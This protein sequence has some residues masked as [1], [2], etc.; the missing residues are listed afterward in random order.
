MPDEEIKLVIA[1]DVSGLVAGTAKAA[2]ATNEAATAMESSAVKMGA[3]GAAISKQAVDAFRQVQASAAGQDNAILQQAA[4]FQASGLSANQAAVALQ[5]LGYGQKESSAAAEWAAAQAFLLSNAQAAEASTAHVAAVAQVEHAASMSH[6]DRAMAHATARIAET[7]SGAGGLG[8]S[9]GRVA[10]QSETLGPILA[11]AFPV[12]GAIALVEI[13]SQV[14]AELAKLADAEQTA[15]D[16]NANFERQLLKSAEALSKMKEKAAELGGGS[17][18]AAAEN[19]S[20]LGNRSLDVTADVKK[21][22][23]RIEDSPGILKQFG[24]AVGTVGVEAWHLFDDASEDAQRDLGTFN[25]QVMD[26]IKQQKDLAPAIQDVERRI[27]VMNEQMSTINLAAYSSSTVENFQRIIAAES[28]FRDSL[29][30]L[31]QSESIERQNIQN[32]MQASLITSEQRAAESRLSVERAQVDSAVRLGMISEEQSRQILDREESQKLAIIRSTYD[33]KR[34]LLEQQAKTN[35]ETD[36]SAAFKS[37][38]EQQAAEESKIATER[39]QIATATQERLVALDQQR[40]K[41][42]EEISIAQSESELK[43]AEQAR[44]TGKITIDEEVIRRK[45]AEQDIYSAKVQAKVA[46]FALAGEDEKKQQ[47]IYT[48]LELL[49]IQHGSKLQ[50]IEA[51]GAKARAEVEEKEWTNSLQKREQD[52]RLSIERMA[53]EQRAKFDTLKIET[54]LNAPVFRHPAEDQGPVTA[55][56]GA[57]G[58]GSPIKETTSDALALAGALAT[59]G[60]PSQELLGNL[61]KI[62]Q[63]VPQIAAAVNEYTVAVEKTKEIKAET[64]QNITTD[65]QQLAIIEQK[66][67]AGVQVAADLERQKELQRD[68]AENTKIATAADKDQHDALTRLAQVTAQVANQMRQAMASSLQQTTAAFNHNLAEWMRG[69]ETFGTAMLRTWVSFAETAIQQLLRIAEQ[70][71]IT[72]AL[73]ALGL[74]SSTSASQQNAQQISGNVAVAA[75]DAAVAA[76]NTLAFE[77]GEGIPWPAAAADAAITYAIGAG[78]SALA[79]YEKGGVVEKTGPAL[80][81]AGEMILTAPASERMQAIFGGVPEAREIN[82]LA[83]TAAATGPGPAGVAADVERNFKVGLDARYQLSGK[84]MPVASA[85]GGMLVAQEML[86]NVHANEMI[87]PAH[88][89]DG[90]Q[91][92]MAGAAGGPGGPGGPG[93]AGGS[94]VSNSTEN[95]F[96]IPI[97]INGGASAADMKDALKTHLIPMI[98]RAVRDGALG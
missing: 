89:S 59:G 27:R 69:N 63:T 62:G 21:L 16:E 23:E 71:L 73:M 18:A 15:A 74:T 34:T 84:A 36:F 40:I 29:V 90:F 77:T 3:T 30:R 8:T 35:P 47:E 93:G 85:A 32:E 44:E 13:L 91:K 17:I 95:H 53:A 33:Q 86:A 49:A 38:S 82:S 72:K 67:S 55:I 24:E 42:S 88:I 57:V 22:N 28:Q 75:S 11:I 54:T 43:T 9:L 10:V 37:L 58:I 26:S 64:Q 6:M 4:A 94:S 52:F 12:F 76:A 14:G 98:R 97:T 68:V 7:I 19:I 96:H 39:I 41:S 66:I 80:V 81:H 65:Q 83:A 31:Q 20:T 78:F 56:T 45:R 1:A 79:A 60:E 5:N 70:W 48:A 51:S 50:E 61:Q 87:L 25:R 46:E 92:I 2:S